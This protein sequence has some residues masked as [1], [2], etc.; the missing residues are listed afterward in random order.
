[1][2]DPIFEEPRLAAIYDPLGGDRRDLDAYVALARELHTHSVLDIGCGTGT[3]ACRLVESGMQVVAV[4]PAA[5]S[6]E[7]ARGK[8]S[9]DRVQ[10]L[11]GDAL[12][13][14]PIEVDLVTMT[15]NV[16]QVFLTE[17]EWESNLQAV[18]ATL[19]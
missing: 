11:V 14:P 8:T 13:L 9:A 19:Q 17:E 15:G 4:D 12:S 3:L 16:A 1:M 10:W 6:I 18:W 2:P 5:A 7:V